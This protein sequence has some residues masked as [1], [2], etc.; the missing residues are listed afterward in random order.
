MGAGAPVDTQRRCRF[1][2]NLVTM[3]GRRITRRPRPWA[4]STGIEPVHPAPEA[5]ALSSEL[6]G[7]LRPHYIPAAPVVSKRGATARAAAERAARGRRSE[8]GTPA[9]RA[10]ARAAEVANRAIG[11]L[12]LARCAVPSYERAGRTAASPPCGCAAHKRDHAFIVPTRPH[13]CPKDAEGV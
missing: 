7:H 11:R 6:R 12:L 10:P 9:Y 2:A 1:R 3:R 5:G 8:A 13:A 4:P